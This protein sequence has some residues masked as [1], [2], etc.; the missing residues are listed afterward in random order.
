METFDQFLQPDEIIAED[1]HKL[2]KLKIS[3]GGQTSHRFNM[4]RGINRKNLRQVPVSQQTTIS[5]P[6]IGGGGVSDFV[7]HIN[8]SH[9]VI[10]LAKKSSSGVWRL[11]KPQVLD[12]A[13]KYKFNVPDQDKPMKHLGSTGIRMIRYRSNIYYLYKPRKHTTKKSIKSAIG[14]TGHFKM[15][16]G[17]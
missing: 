2:G 17:L 7:R 11:S 9:K 15:G 16:M 5:A 1:L 13:R 8:I 6:D 3:R 10:D 4:A 14:K 12:I